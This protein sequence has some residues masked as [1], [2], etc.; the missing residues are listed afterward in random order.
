MQHSFAHR[1]PPRRPYSN[2]K[3]LVLVAQFKAAAVGGK[4]GK[5]RRH[6]GRG[7]FFIESKPWI[8]PPL[9]HNE[10]RARTY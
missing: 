4:Q 9:P 1:S 3:S 2:V 10:M 6:R 5:K 8:E 7:R